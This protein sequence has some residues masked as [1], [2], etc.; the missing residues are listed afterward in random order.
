MYFKNNL[1]VDENGNLTIK[2]MYQQIT[3]KGSHLNKFSF[4]V[5]GKGNASE[6]QVFR[7][8]VKFFYDDQKDN[9]FYFDFEKHFNY[10]QSINEFVT[11][12]KDFNKIE[13][14]VE[15]ESSCEVYL[16]V[17]QLYYDACGA[18]YFYDKNQNIS[19][20]MT[21]DSNSTKI[22]YGK[23]DRI[24]K[25]FN[26]NGEA[27]TYKYNKDDILYQIIDN[28]GNY[29]KFTYNSK[30]LI[31]EKGFYNKDNI[32]LYCIKFEY[33]SS[34]NLIKSINEFN[35][36]TSHEYNF[37]NFQTSTTFSD[38]T[39][40]ERNC[41][42]D[43]TLNNIRF[44]Y[45]PNNQQQ[46]YSTFNTY[47]ELKNINKMTTF[48]NLDYN[49]NKTINPNATK[50]EEILIENNLL[51]KLHYNSI[52][53]TIN[54][55][56]VTKK[57]GYNN[58]IY[59]FE[60]DDL[61]RMISVTIN[62]IKTYQ[63]N[64]D[65]F[66]RIVEIKDLV[67]NKVE[68]FN[69]DL[70]NNL[71]QYCL[72][73]RSTSYT[74]DNQQN[75]Q[76]LTFE[77]INSYHNYSY[78]Y[79][80]EHV[81]KNLDNFIYLLTD[82]L[83][84]DVVYP[85]LET[86]KGMFGAELDYED[87]VAI[88][89]AH[90][91][92]NNN[93]VIKTK[94]ELIYKKDS[95]NSKKTASNQ[96]NEKVKNWQ[97]QFENTQSIFLLFKP[98]EI[99]NTDIDSYYVASVT[100][101]NYLEMGS[102]FINS[103]GSVYFKDHTTNS[104]CCRIN[105]K[106]KF[107]QWNLIG[108]SI[109]Y[110]N[111]K[112][113]VTIYCNGFASS[114]SLLNHKFACDYFRINNAK[115]L[116]NIVDEDNDD[117]SY[118]FSLGFISFG[119][120]VMQDDTCSRLYNELLKCI[121]TQIESKESGVCYN[122]E[123]SGFDV[124]S[125]NST[126]ISQNKVKP[127]KIFEVPFEESKIKT[128]DFFK[129]DEQLKRFVYKARSY[130]NY[131]N[132]HYYQDVSY[133]I[134]EKGILT[135]MF[136]QETTNKS[137][138]GMVN[139]G[140]KY[141]FKCFYSNLNFFINESSVATKE[142]EFDKWYRLTIFYSSSY[143]KVYIDK[144]LFYSG[145]N[146]YNF[147]QSEINFGNEFDGCFSMFA[148]SNYE[149]TSSNLNSVIN[150]LEN[151]FT[152]ITYKKKYDE[153]NR[154]VEENIYTSNTTISK[155][156]TY[157]INNLASIEDDTSLTS[158]SY[159]D[160]GSVSSINTLNKENN[161]QSTVSYQY[162]TFNRLIKT[163]NGQNVEEVTYDEDGNILTIVKTSNSQQV[164][165]KT[166]TYNLNKLTAVTDS[167]DSSSNISITYNGFYPSSINNTVL[168]W[169]G[170]RLKQYGDI[171]S[172]EYN[173]LGIRTSKQVGNKR[174]NYF[175]EG[176]RILAMDIHDGDLQYSF[177]LVFDYDESGK[178]I[179]VSEPGYTLFYIRDGLG[180]IIKLVDEQG[181]DVVKYSYD[182]WGKVTINTISSLHPSARFNPFMYKG[183]IYDVETQLYYCNSRY[184]SPE[185]CR[186][187]SPD[188]IE[189][190]EPESINGLNLYTYCNNDP[191]NKYDPSGHS[192]I[193]V[194]VL[195]GTLFGAA[196]GF[197]FD[198]GKQLI[199]NGW[200]FSEVDWGSAVNSAIVGGA[201]GFSLA[202]GV[203]Y[204]GPVIAGAAATGGLTAGGAFAISTAVSFGAG[205][206]GYATE[207]WMNGRTPSFGKAMMHGGFV[208]LEGMVN[209]G[210]GGIVGSIGNVGTKGK[211]LVSKEWW[212]KFI[213]GLEFTQPFKIGIDYIRK[214]I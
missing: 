123:K 205:A 98:V 137:A 210:V 188:S 211:F 54:N 64:Y 93:Y 120:R 164:S 189:Y 30:N 86:C 12:E 178:L 112:S 19:E 49:F 110:Q 162:D 193:L 65:E 186:W 99:N 149:E 169:E 172:Y 111:Q 143:L 158:Y 81:N 142:I 125:F 60:Y 47:D 175:V 1:T 10:W 204:F 144:E 159:N 75:P 154:I 6:N 69:Y 8:Y 24:D 183:Y 57:E 3:L 29:V 108:F 141:E 199:N 13:V 9:T 157:N 168:S 55:E 174:Y 187:I 197:G 7:A 126:F 68:Y 195:I 184:Y 90:S 101:Q 52:T 129:Y 61:D 26:S 51:E 170:K 67:K 173:S 138:R 151:A 56:L 152:P 53:S 88:F 122:Y 166:F 107:N 177:Y 104:T 89:E 16:N 96:A 20:Y 165:S 59:E 106:L 25:I 182:S 21:A 31:T 85:N 48:K 38:G 185:L 207:E 50:I 150:E 83:N 127:T 66:D 39:K 11:P 100:D 202:M 84:D 92:L 91:D 190:L 121:E 160:S 14:G 118:I 156:Y 163:T 79:I 135:F 115:Q 116:T 102:L 103:S 206:L 94:N 15:I 139:I 140:T 36:E 63:Y 40:L 2:K 42:S 191:V 17:F 97:K 208:A 45:I 117:S 43:E 77:N 114:S 167:V 201:L 46:Y 22:I 119:N 171:A 95:I 113:E 27:L 192:A 196:V 78:E 180:N 87:N 33:D 70:N 130:F 80:Y 194:M 148:F 200:D 18:Y 155:S 133:K 131:K 145:L 161:Q 41:N 146:S 179:S 23:A 124:V 44:Y 214:N 209:F 34:G 73:N 132:L 203:G 32:K 5:L 176:D 105:N 134:P 76:T 62:G 109:D 35:K 181:N 213:F 212:G 136:K 28:K 58:T 198:A 147:G 72:D 74:Y 71:L 37:S 128:S 153:Q 4:S 82:K